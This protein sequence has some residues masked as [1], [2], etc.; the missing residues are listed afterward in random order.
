MSIKDVIKNS[1]YESLGGG[2]NLSAKS[3]LLLLMIAALVGIYIFMVYKL[4][5]KAQKIL[6][7]TGLLL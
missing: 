2:T 7:K 3:I 1:V 5:M 4:P 6:A